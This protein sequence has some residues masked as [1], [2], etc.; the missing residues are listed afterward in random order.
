M[1]G[2]IKTFRNDAVPMWVNIDKM[3]D[4]LFSDVPEWDARIPAVDIREEEDRYSLEAELPGLSEKDVE[5]KVEDSI[6][7]IQSSKNEENERKSEGFLLK[8]RR[9]SAFKRSFVLP[10]DIDR[11]GIEAKF[12][13]G[14]LSIEIRKTPELQPKTIEVRSA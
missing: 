9:S 14:I 10:K 7:T 12:K 13:N 8:E 5:V 2:L 6:L 11:E 1:N 4:S 3:M